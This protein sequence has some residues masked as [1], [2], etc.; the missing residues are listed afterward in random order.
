MRED[1]TAF[2]PEAFSA[3]VDGPTPQFVSSAA[4]EQDVAGCVTLA[5][6]V[7][8]GTS[9][10]WAALFRRDIDRSDRCLAVA[11][12]GD[13]LIAYG[14][15]AWFEPDAGAPA[16]AAPAG[17][18]LIGLVVAPSWR[19]RG[20]GAAIIQARLAWVAKRAC[21]AWYFANV[22]NRASI[23]LHE[24]AGF[25]TVTT[26]FWFPSVTDGESSHLLGRAQLP[27]R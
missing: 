18:Y 16:N 15:T 2:E 26:D 6:L 17:Y 14:R 24:Q 27:R 20:V 13:E 8:D 9:E 21:E 4:T 19:R 25:T 7:A 22:A 23:Q 1:R 11:R 3:G 5:G 12:V 10:A